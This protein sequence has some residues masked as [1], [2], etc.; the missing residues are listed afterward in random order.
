M[1]NNG[2]S[3]EPWR[4]PTFTSKLFV[5]P[6]RVLLDVVHALYHLNV[7]FSNIFHYLCPPYDISWHSVICFFEIYKVHNCVDI[8]FFPNAFHEDDKYLTGYLNIMIICI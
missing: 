8:V 6:C 1:N 5:G 2:L 7:F 4:R 3:A